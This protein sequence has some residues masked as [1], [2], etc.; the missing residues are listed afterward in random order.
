MRKDHFFSLEK[1]RQ[2]D[3]ILVSE[4][5]ARLSRH[6]CC[7]DL[8]LMVTNDKWKRIIQ[9]RVGRSLDQILGKS[10]S[11]RTNTIWALEQVSH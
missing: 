10:S 2:N 8:F 5:L 6:S 1:K 3:L 9:E 7:D 11:L 4:F